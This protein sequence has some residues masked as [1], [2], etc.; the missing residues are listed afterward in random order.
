MHTVDFI[1]I[2]V[3]LVIA[4]GYALTS[5]TYTARRYRRERDA[6]RYELHQV[7]HEA[8]HEVSR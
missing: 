2:L 3:M 1:I 4:C 5:L 7:L 8:R 6:A